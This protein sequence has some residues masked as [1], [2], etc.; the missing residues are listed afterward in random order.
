MCC[1]TNEVTNISESSLN[2]STD[3]DLLKNQIN[4]TKADVILKDKQIQRMKSEFEAF[5]NEAIKMEEDLNVL[6]S[7]QKAKIDELTCLVNNFNANSNTVD[8]GKKDVF[9]Q[10]FNTHKSQL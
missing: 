5:Q 6:L 3:L 1:P 2:S 10:T 4:E 7:E 9:T 8:S